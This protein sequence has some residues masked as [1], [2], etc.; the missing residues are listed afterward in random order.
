MI[1][2]AKF[3]QRGG[4]QILDLI[5]DED[6]HDLASGVL[7]LQHIA[8]NANVAFVGIAVLI[9][10]HEAHK[11]L[12]PLG[13]GRIGRLGRRPLRFFDVFGR[14][15]LFRLARRLAMLCSLTKRRGERRRQKKARDERIE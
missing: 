11:V 15:G 10:L 13:R 5:R 6:R 14:L 4:Q 1:G 3:A 8:I 9:A 2:H 12:A 7:M